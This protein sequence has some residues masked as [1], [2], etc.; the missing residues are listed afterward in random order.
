MERNKKNP[1]PWAQF[2]S[3]GIATKYLLSK[4]GVKTYFPMPKKEVNT[5]G[6]KKITQST[7]TKQQLVAAPVAVARRTG[8]KAASSLS[9]KN[10]YRESGREYYGNVVIP[11]GATAGT[12]LV[13]I[14]VSPQQFVNRRLGV[15]STLFELYEMRKFEVIYVP[16]CSTSQTGSICGFIDPDPSDP[17][18]TGSPN[19]NKAT[20]QAGSSGEKVMWM[21][22]VTRYVKDTKRTDLFTNDSTDVRFSQ[23]GVYNLVLVVVPTGTLPLQ[24]GSLYVNYEI[25]LKTPTN[26][27]TSALNPSGYNQGQVQM[28]P[29][30]VN[31]SIIWPS[32][33]T[34]A[35]DPS[36]TIG[37]ANPAD[38]VLTLSNLDPSRRYRVLSICT[39]SNGGAAPGTFPLSSPTNGWFIESG[40]SEFLGLS[41]TTVLCATF[42]IYTDGSTTSTSLSFGSVIGGTS[43]TLAVHIAVYGLQGTIGVTAKAA[44][45]RGDML[46][47]N[48]A[49]VARISK[50]EC[51]MSQANVTDA[52]G[53]SVSTVTCFSGPRSSG[54]SDAQSRSANWRGY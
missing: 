36:S 50:L 14:V 4:V 2:L 51:L 48:A 17:A 1:S 20:S 7:M 18:I 29:K 11:S 38:N 30:N 27:T 53:P 37:F 42:I 52:N 15:L 28:V 12:N 40:D 54:P 8:I 16:S 13:S 49:L 22:H 41:S 24:I 33:G 46:D 31:P 21:E 26:D 10:E 39:W 34:Y 44:R 19:I 3:L 47:A 25:I 9:R 45:I 5:H 6:K 35:L 32:S 43:G 23:V